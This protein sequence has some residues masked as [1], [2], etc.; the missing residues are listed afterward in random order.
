MKI[1]KVVFLLLII[2]TSSCIKNNNNPVPSI[3]FDIT[4]DIN[5]PSYNQLQG[6]G[7]W[8]YVVGGSRGIIVYRRSIDE[9]VAFDRHSPMD[10]NGTCFLPLFPDQDNFLQLKVRGIL[11]PLLI[12]T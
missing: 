4:I 2:I 12:S 3:P 8:T 9:F 6:V 11:S 10:P 1:Q 5:L 7:A